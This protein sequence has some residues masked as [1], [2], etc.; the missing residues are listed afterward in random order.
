MAAV[1]LALAPV[2]LRNVQL[3]SYMKDLAQAN[4]AGD[5]TLGTQIAAR[6]HDLKLPVL[7]SDVHISHEGNKLRIEAKYA[8]LKDFGLYQVDLHFHPSAASR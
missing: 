7:A 8:V 5:E 2:Y 3:Q 6:A 1:L 4:R